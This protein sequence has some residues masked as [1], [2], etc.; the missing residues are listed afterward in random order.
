MNSL[1]LLPLSS[2]ALLFAGALSAA[3]AEGAGAS[4]SDG[5]ADAIG[6]PAQPGATST[7]PGLCPEGFFRDD[8]VCVS[9]PDFDGELPLLEPEENI[10]R[11]IGRASCRERV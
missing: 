6:T 8:D 3:N 9:F 10:H 1:P 2:A 5:P 11:E 4:A 7:E